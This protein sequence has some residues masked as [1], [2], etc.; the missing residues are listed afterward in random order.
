M[1]KQKAFILVLGLVQVVVTVQTYWHTN[2]CHF[3]VSSSIFGA[4][5]LSI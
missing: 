2:Q 4:V 5:S 3:V 1:Q